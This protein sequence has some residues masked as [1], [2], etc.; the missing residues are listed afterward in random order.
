MKKK[1]KKT[2]IAIVCILIALWIAMGAADVL[3]VTH[4][5]RPFFCKL[6][7]SLDDGGSGLYKGLGYSVYIEG[8]F[9]PLEENPGVTHYDMRLLG[10]NV[11]S[12]DRQ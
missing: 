7:E 8:N 5:R 9:L 1:T 10:F 4:W 11:K 12:A 3:L 6:T 2:L